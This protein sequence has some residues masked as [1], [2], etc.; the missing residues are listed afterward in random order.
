V[1]TVGVSTDGHGRAALAARSGLMRAES[2][3]GFESRTS[4]LRVRCFALI[5]W[6]YLV[7]NDADT[8]RELLL[9]PV[10]RYLRR[11]ADTGC[12]RSVPGHPSKHGVNISGHR[13]RPLWQLV[14][15][16]VG[17]ADGAE[18]MQVEGGVRP[19]CRRSVRSQHTG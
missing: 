1:G 12:C 19:A 8:C 9:C 17:C 18:A 4:G 10:A 3:E 2:A 11:A 15:L 5:F 14:A 7:P 13:S 6:S 16:A